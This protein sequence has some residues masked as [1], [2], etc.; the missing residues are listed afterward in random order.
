MAIEDFVDWCRRMN[1][2]KLG[3]AGLKLSE[4]SLGSWVTYGGQV[5]EEVAVK[6]MSIAYDM[7]VNFFDSAE[8]YADGKGEIV[9]GNI[10]N[11]LGS[12]R[13]SIVEY[14]KLFFC[15]DRPH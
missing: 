11:K 7:G 2:R 10:F 13:E 8:A 4:L 15:D 5:G 3:A 12:P 1:Y 6:C 9:M 14:T